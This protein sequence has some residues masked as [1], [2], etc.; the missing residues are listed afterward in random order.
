MLLILIPIAW[1]AVVMLVLAACSMAS[2]AD[3][4]LLAATAETA[5]V[6]A[7]SSA[8]SSAP[9]AITDGGR[10]RAHQRRRQ[11]PSGQAPVRGRRPAEPR[12]RTVG[13]DGSVRAD[14]GSRTGVG[15][16]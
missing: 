15:A 7:D 3:R 14:R 2:R 4:S 13:D 1:L 10:D 9:R 16:R 12:R 8:M 5:A 6:M 11:S